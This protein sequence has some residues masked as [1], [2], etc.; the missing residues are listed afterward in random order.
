MNLALSEG[1]A[2]G[3][4]QPLLGAKEQ[5]FF[6]SPNRWQCPPLLPGQLWVVD[7]QFH[8]FKQID[9][10]AGE[11]EAHR[12]DCPSSLPDPLLTTANVINTNCSAAHSRQALSCKMAVEYDKFIESGRK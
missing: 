2:L 3:Y 1:A 6:K 5:G 9:C 7:K 4:K 12:T 10:V 8:S 11:R